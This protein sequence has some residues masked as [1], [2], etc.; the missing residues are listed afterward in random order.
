MPKGVYQRKSS[1]KLTQIRE[2]YD[3]KHGIETDSTKQWGNSERVGTGE[4]IDNFSVGNSFETPIEYIEGTERTTSDVDYRHQSI[5]GRTTDRQGFDR[6]L[7]RGNGFTDIKDEYSDRSINNIV[8]SDESRVGSKQTTAL[9]KI[10][11]TIPITPDKPDKTEVKPLKLITQPMSTIEANAMRQK[12]YQAFVGFFGFIDDFLKMIVDG[13][14]KVEIWSTIEDVDIYVM[15][16]RALINAQKSVVVAQNIRRAVWLWDQVQIG[17]ILGPRFVESWQLLS[18]K[19]F[20]IPGTKRG[21]G[22]YG[23]IK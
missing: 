4:Q 16:D 11:K 23:R 7:Y 10:K 2:R 3:K 8:S 14:E 22:F 1:Q 6:E 19:G 17:T 12:L 15:V 9:K 18:T 20:S 5:A 21:S 13:H